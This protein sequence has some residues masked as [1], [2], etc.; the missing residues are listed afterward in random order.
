MS[1]SKST[2][3]YGAIINYKKEV[4]ETYNLLSE[5][6]K[7]PLFKDIKGKFVDM[8][9]IEL[10]EV[11]VREP[12]S[13]RRGLISSSMIPSESKQD[14]AI[15]NLELALAATD[16]STKEINKND[17][18]KFAKAVSEV[19]K[20]LDDEDIA[21]KPRLKKAAT[22]AMSKAYLRSIEL[23]DYFK[24][25]DK[26][27][28][29]LKQRYERLRDGLAQRYEERKEEIETMFDPELMNQ[30]MNAKQEIQK[31]GLNKGAVQARL[32]AAEAEAERMEPEVSALE[33]KI[34]GDGR[35]FFGRMLSKIGLEEQSKINETVANRWCELAGIKVLKS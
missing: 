23:L 21:E 25:K 32:R 20:V 35:G 30:I 26:K 24:Q 22:L 3:V 8:K 13:R 6:V 14:R 31:V 17:V 9:E 33:R 19:S 5:I 27:L 18:E 28:E 4:K 16:V 15:G 10:H 34:K 12:T 11:F 7:N 29:D 1:I 2:I